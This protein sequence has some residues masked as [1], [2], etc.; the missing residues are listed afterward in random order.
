MMN[1]RYEFGLIRG[2]L[3]CTSE[4]SMVRAVMTAVD[5]KSAPAST[6]ELSSEEPM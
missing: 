6:V 2:D 1:I 4:T 5:M 3:D